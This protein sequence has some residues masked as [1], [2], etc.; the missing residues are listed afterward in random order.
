M[1]KPEE[2]FLL[3]GKAAICMDWEAQKDELLNLVVVIYNVD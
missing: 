2:N 1:L 3:I